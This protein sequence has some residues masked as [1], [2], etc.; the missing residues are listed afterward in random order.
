MAL[1]EGRCTNCGSILMLDPRMEKGHCLYCDAVFENARA[2]ELYA[3][4]SD[5]EFPNLPQ[6]KYE[7]P[8]L[9]PVP[10]HA[11]LPKAVQSNSQPTAQK[12]A[13]TAKYI[14]ENKNVPDFNLSS[15]QIMLL[16][17]VFLA[18]VG[19]FSAI[20]LPQTIRRDRLRSEIREKLDPSLISEGQ[21]DPFSLTD[22]LQFR[23]MDNSE[24]VMSL[25][26]EVDEEKAKEI[27]RHFS[28]VRAE[29]LDLDKDNSSQVYGPVKLLL[30]SSGDKGGYR[31]T[32][33]TK[34]NE[35]I[36]NDFVSEKVEA[37]ETNEESKDL[38]KE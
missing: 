16:V 4:A 2:F 27:F 7:G 5:Y 28:E 35:M 1:Q 21:D 24:V 14:V 36:L 31:I 8:N 32:Y 6:E 9:D 20:M 3:D 13:P 26:T 15:R 22:H 29:V 23:R 19:L 25:G 17:A 18:I 30:A 38:E 12:Q 11:P 34:T 33:D 37:K 10:V